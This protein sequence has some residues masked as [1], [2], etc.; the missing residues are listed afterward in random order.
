MATEECAICGDSVPFATTTHVLVNPKHVEGVAD[1]YVCRPC[2]DEH[3]E[4]LFVALEAEDGAAA[5]DEDGNDLAVNVV[6]ERSED[7]AHGERPEGND[8]TETAGVGRDDG[9]RLDPSASE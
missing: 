6:D 9:D 1:H 5:D 4:G 8:R 7:G 3:L 2:Y